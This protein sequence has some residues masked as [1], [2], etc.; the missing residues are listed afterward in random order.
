[1]DHFSSFA[2]IPTIMA[3]C[4]FVAD[5]YKWMVT[6]EDGETISPKA[7][8]FIPILCGLIGLIIGVWSFYTN[9]DIIHSDNVLAAAATGMTSGLASVGLRQ[10]DYYQRKKEK[11]DG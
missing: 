9:P 1:M 11:A 6:E 8:A 5:A 7:V 10:K 4:F 3:I 2:S